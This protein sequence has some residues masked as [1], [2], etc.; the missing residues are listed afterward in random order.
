MSFIANQAREQ[1]LQL[2]RE[3]SRLMYKYGDVLRKRAF[4]FRLKVIAIV[5][6]CTV[7]VLTLIVLSAL[8]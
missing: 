3:Q 6:T 5:A 8:I 7:A 2:E 4:W 1:G